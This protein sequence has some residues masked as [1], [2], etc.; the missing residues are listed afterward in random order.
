MENTYIT[1]AKYLTEK[2]S[3]FVGHLSYIIILAIYK[4][5]IVLSIW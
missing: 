4:M 2:N 1:L 3:K 5:T